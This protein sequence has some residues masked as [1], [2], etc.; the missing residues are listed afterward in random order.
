MHNVSAD[1]E[2]QLQQLQKLQFQ[3]N[4][5]SSLDLMPASCQL[6]LAVMVND[7]L[8]HRMLQSLTYGMAWHQRT[9]QLGTLRI[10]CRKAHMQMQEQFPTDLRQF[11]LQVS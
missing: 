6:Q 1:P 10:P 8:C 2:Q 4:H 3:V 11:Q 9:H 5:L 7:E